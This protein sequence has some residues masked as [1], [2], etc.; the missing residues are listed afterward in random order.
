MAVPEINVIYE[1]NEIS[2][3]NLGPSTKPSMKPVSGVS[4]PTD[5]SDKYVKNITVI[6]RASLVVPSH[7]LS[8]HLSP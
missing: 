8:S 3:S 7:D 2:Y 5:R 4:R 1:T 6:A